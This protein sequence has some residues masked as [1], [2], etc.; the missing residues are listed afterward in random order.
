MRNR[1]H[2]YVLA[3]SLASAAF[4][5]AQTSQPFDRDTYRGPTTDATYTPLATTQSSDR[6][7]AIHVEPIPEQMRRERD[8]SPFYVKHVVIRGVPVIAS[9]RVSDHA[10]LEAAYK[11]D[12]MLADSPEWVRAALVNAKVRLAVIGVV[13]YSLDLPENAAGDMNRD[14]KSAAFWDERARG[15]GGLPDASCGEENLLNL[16]SDPYRAED[17]GIHEFAHTLAS[18]LQQADPTWYERL[19]ETYRYAM[20]AGRFKGTY[21]ASNEQEYWAE[22]AQMWFDCAVPHAVKNVHDGRWTREQIKAYDAELAKLL[23]EVYGD[24]AWRY[25]RTDGKPLTVDGVEYTRPAEEL[26][27]LK[28]LDRDALPKFSFAKSPRIIA[29]RATTKPTTAP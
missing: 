12:H 18:A 10:L 13:E 5:I 4:V 15:T 9:A 8:L 2:A 11:L 1:L 25:V 26:A 3:G 24:G 20:D 21:N 28:G 27:H 14:L 17:I 29:Y 7:A 23:A 6:P 19:R 16:A 22:G